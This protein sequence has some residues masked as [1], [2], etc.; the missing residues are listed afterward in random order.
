MIG[1]AHD[2]WQDPQGTQ[3]MPQVQSNIQLM[4]PVENTPSG[5][6]LIKAD[7]SPAPQPINFTQNGNS[8]SITVD[9]LSVWDL[10]YI[11]P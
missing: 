3:V 5:V 7:E 6:F 2:N 8:I 9:K 11:K 10:I 4:I 1:I